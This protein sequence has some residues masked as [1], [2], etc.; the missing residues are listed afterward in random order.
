MRNNLPK[1]VR[2]NECGIVNL[3]DKENIG[4]HWVAYVKRCGNEA[5]YFD[6]FGNLKPPCE[7]IKYLSSGGSCKIKYNHTQFQTYD[8][9]NCGHLCLWFLYNESGAADADS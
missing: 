5:V 1:S 7:V 4:T 3:D 6:S 8:T 2:I 9:E